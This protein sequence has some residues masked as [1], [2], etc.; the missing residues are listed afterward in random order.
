MEHQTEHRMEVRGAAMV[1]R[2]EVLDGPTG[3]RN[4][5]DELKARIVA[6]T[7]LPGARVCD[8]AAKYGVLAQHLSSWRGLARKGL[9]A[10][11]MPQ[12]PAFVPIM[13]DAPTDPAPTKA[14]VAKAAAELRIEI[15]G[16]IVHVPA[17]CPP[18]RA[19]AVAAALRQAR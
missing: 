12:E 5:P 18:E 15:G 6:E 3:R 13:L 19:A 16:A 2:M 9:L 17:D 10:L 7:M 1:S 11:P 14:T 8:V 4:W